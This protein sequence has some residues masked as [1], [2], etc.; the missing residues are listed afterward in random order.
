L[1]SSVP[2]PVI[3]N[4]GQLLPARVLQRVD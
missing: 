1:A 2:F 4:K 3:V